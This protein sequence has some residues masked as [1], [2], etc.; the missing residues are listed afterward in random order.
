[1]DAS[2]K[3]SCQGALTA[4][5]IEGFRKHE[6]CPKLRSVGGQRNKQQI[7]P[8]HFAR[9]SV[10]HYAQHR[11]QAARIRPI[12]EK[13][14][15]LFALYSVVE[16]VHVCPVFGPRLAKFGSN[17]G[18]RLVT[19]GQHCPDSGRLYPP[20]CHLTGRPSSYAPSRP[21]ARTAQ[22]GRWPL[23]LASRGVHSKTLPISQLSFFLS[24]A[25]LAPHAGRT[26]DEWVA[27]TSMASK[28]PPHEL[29]ARKASLV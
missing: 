13:S 27:S 7:V 17:S 14:G 22:A 19:F 16:L 18:Q 8:R 4:E 6:Q 29:A 25:A 3:Q 21:T 20:D 15:R 9:E 2:H 28:G 24:H 1:M 10:K 5:E 23:P 26:I 12:L 11:A